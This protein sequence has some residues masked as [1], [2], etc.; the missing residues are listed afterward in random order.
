MAEE[1]ELLRAAVDRACVADACDDYPDRDDRC[2]MVHELHMKYVHVRDALREAATDRDSAIAQLGKL[3]DAVA[4]V[5]ADLPN[6]QN[7]TWVERLYRFA[8]HKRGE[9]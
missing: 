7:E 1:L 2:A 4:F 6:V 3:R 5:S 9:S 8:L